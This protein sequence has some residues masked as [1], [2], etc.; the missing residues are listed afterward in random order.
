MAPT[1][2]KWTGRKWKALFQ[3]VKLLCLI[4]NIFFFVILCIF[5][6]FYNDLELILE[7]EKKGRAGSRSYCPQNKIRS[8]QNGIQ[9]L[10]KS[11]PQHSL[12][13]HYS[14]HSLFRSAARPVCSQHCPLLWFYA[15]VYQVCFSPTQRRTFWPWRSLLQKP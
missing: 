14:P 8:S 2:E 11:S 6:N 3:T 13:L 9:G 7:S 1:C 5:Q 4:G 10:A 15:P 12:A